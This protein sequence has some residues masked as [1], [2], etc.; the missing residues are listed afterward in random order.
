MLTIS[1]LGQS[2][3]SQETIDSFIEALKE[4]SAQEKSLRQRYVELTA[5]MNMGGIPGVVLHDYI[6]AA[7]KMNTLIAYNLKLFRDGG[8]VGAYVPIPMIHVGREFA[9]DEV[10]SLADVSFEPCPEPP[11][12][13][14]SWP[15]VTYEALK[16]ARN[17]IVIGGLVWALREVPNFVRSIKGA[18]TEIAYYNKVVAEVKAASDQLKAQNDTFARQMDQCVA[19]G[20]SR[21][22]CLKEVSD[23]LVKIRQGIIKPGKQ[24]EE[25][26]GLGFF[27]W[28]GVV[29]FVGGL[30]A[31]G[32]AVWKRKRRAGS[33]EEKPEE[34]QGS[35]LRREAMMPGE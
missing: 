15:L 9:D 8:G 10:V 24:Y 20:K 35:V 25:K 3:V 2:E 16:L 7:T 4:T 27:G 21:T 22:E 6:N 33:Y 13:L 29:V 32:Y 19:A 11:G 12:Q 5:W 18:D 34:S 28:I 1:G 14:G 30:G 23:I 17:I 31:V 26:G